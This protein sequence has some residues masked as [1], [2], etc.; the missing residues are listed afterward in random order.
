[1]LL[2]FSPGRKA[3]SKMG[4]IATKLLGEGRERE[5]GGRWI[6]L[7]GIWRFQDQILAFGGGVLSRWESRPRRNGNKWEKSGECLLWSGNWWKWIGNWL[8]GVLANVENGLRITI[9]LSNNLRKLRVD[10]WKTIQWRV[11]LIDW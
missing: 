5:T 7:D 2:N 3:G 11:N 10:W 1:M 6:L 4:N 8:Y 9:Q